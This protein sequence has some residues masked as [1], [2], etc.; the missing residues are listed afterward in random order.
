[1]VAFAMS[2]L[3]VQ[4][5]A[6]PFDLRESYGKTPAQIVAMGFDKWYDFYI[7]KVGSETTMSMSYSS[8]IYGDALGRV[9]DSRLAKLP[10]ERRKMIL[11]MRQPMIDYRNACIEIGRSRS[12]GGTLWNLVGASTW[13]ETEEVVAR[14]ID[15]KKKGFSATQVQVRQLWDK[16]LLK[17]ESEHADV[18]AASSI[19]GVNY[20]ELVAF[21]RAGKS[22]FER[23]LGMIGSFASSRDRG[24]ILAFYFAGADIAYNAEM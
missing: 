24:L 11:G 12:G 5:S 3:M 6:E 4:G 7:K 14:L 20:A 17:I 9:N 23:D 22:R 10:V 19:S 1:M 21:V 16:I 13:M 2:L 8:M 18:E 15:P